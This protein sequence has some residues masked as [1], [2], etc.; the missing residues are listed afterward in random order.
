MSKILQVLKNP[1]KIFGFLCGKYE[2][3][4][5][6]DEV[7]LKLRYRA[8]FGSKLNLLNPTGY[9]EKIQ[10]LKLYD[11][12]PQY[13]TLVDKA[14]VKDYVAK[15]IG[16]QYII[17]TLG[18]WNNFDEI[19]FDMLPNQF[20]LKST[21]DS[22][23]LIICKDKKKLDKVKAKIKIEKSLRRNF[24]FEGRQW[25]YKNVNP[26]VIAEQYMVDESGYELKDYKFFCFDGEPK[27]MFIASDR[28]KEG[29]DTKFDFFDMKFKHLNLKN[30]HP[31]SD[32]M[33]SKPESFEKMK[34]LAAILSKGIPHVRID[35]YDINGKIYF[36]EMTFFHHS[37]FCPFE[38]S[39][40][41]KKLGSW[42]RLPEKSNCESSSI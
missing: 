33:I 42:I 19:D 10:W 20:V 7:Y 8:V 37:G 2:F 4:W 17:P 28:G 13:T 6:S 36:G 30:G 9:N 5:L 15:I 35:F 23:G 16:K 25:P 12:K 24:Y 41:D 29:E 32:K 3:K 31:M 1:Y 27:I 21:H 39:E 40:W 11:R 22:G 14:E 26:R 34:E 18:I 38:P